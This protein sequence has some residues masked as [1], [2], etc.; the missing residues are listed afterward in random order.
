MVKFLVD[1][2]FTSILMA[3]IREEMLLMACY[4]EKESLSRKQESLNMKEIG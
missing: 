4:K 1:R 2:V 3:L